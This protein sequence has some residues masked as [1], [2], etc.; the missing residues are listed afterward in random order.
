M[1][2]RGRVYPSSD[3]IDSEY[4]AIVHS[5]RAFTIRGES[6]ARSVEEVSARIEAPWAVAGEC[7]AV[8]RTVGIFRAGPERAGRPVAGGFI[9]A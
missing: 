7:D 3:G 2:G 8:R 1:R 5:V 6:P 4:A 9:V